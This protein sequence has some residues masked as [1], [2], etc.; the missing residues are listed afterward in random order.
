MSMCR[1]MNVSG[2]MKLISCLGE[3]DDSITASNYELE[4]PLKSINYTEN[5]YRYGNNPT[6]VN[7][8]TQMPDLNETYEY[9]YDYEDVGDMQWTLVIKL[10]MYYIPFLIVVGFVG[11][12]LSCV[13]FL[14][15]R[16]RMRSSSYYLAALAVADVSY[17]FI[18]FLVWLDML[19]FNTFNINVFCQ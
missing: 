18:L 19:G 4:H 1:F 10:N 6:I 7:E 5:Q 8:N 2:V 9:D 14:N 17:L 16:L 15:T 13:V 3:M 12:L 11:N